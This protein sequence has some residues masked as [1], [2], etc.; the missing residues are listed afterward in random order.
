MAFYH[1]GSGLKDGVYQRQPHTPGAKSLKKSMKMPYNSKE[2]KPFIYRGQK[3]IGIKQHQR[4]NNSFMFDVSIQRI[5]KKVR[6]RKFITIDEDKT[7]LYHILLDQYTE[8]RADIKDGYFIEAI[9]FDKAFKRAMNIKSISQRWYDLQVATYRNHIKKTLGELN[10]MDIEPYHVDNVLVKIRTK[11]PSTQKSIMDIVKM[12]LRHALEDKLIKNLPLEVR[13]SIKVIS[14]QQKTIVTDAQNKYITVHRSILKVFNSDLAMLCIFLFGLYGRRKAEIL[15]MTWQQID[16]KNNQYTI[17]GTH[18][19]VKIDFVFALPNEISS[20]L[21]KLKGQRRG[22]IFKNENTDQE[23]SNIQPHIEKIRR[24][25][26][27]NKFTFHSMRNL[28]A[29]M[30]HSQGVSASYIS[31]VLGHTNPTTVQQYLTM[32]RVQPLI[33]E[34]INLTLYGVKEF[35]SCRPKEAQDELDKVFKE[36]KQCT[37]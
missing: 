25:S 5:G 9:T 21:L 18:S 32:E 33:E 6:K 12:T 36:L 28:L 22:L 29:S 20:S 11:A 16:F 24:V 4:N 27:W 34:E 15:R 26:G 3:L 2:W 10:L 7:K 30:L 31:S 8:Y 35:K 13:H 37:K 23:Y 14:A 17:P 19:K 1:M